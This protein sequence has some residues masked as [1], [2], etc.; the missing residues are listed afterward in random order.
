GANMALRARLFAHHRFD[1][2]VGPSD[3]ASYA[4][5]SEYEL[6]RRLRRAG[7]RFVH[8]PTAGVRHFILP[9]QIERSW[10]L[11][12]AER[13][14][15]G[16]ARIK[17]ERVPRTAFGWVPLLARLTAAEWRARWARH[18][19]DPERFGFEQRAH[20]WRG[21]AAES[22]RLRRERRERAGAA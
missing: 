6:L 3:A 12:R 1:E 20:Y 11:A 19:P 22:R 15:R 16:S 21:Y 17:G 4:Q 5:G 18:R 7:E 14:G 9:H 8:V 10:L 13:V 2:S